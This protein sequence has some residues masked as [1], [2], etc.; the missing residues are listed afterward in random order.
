MVSLLKQILV[1]VG[2]VMASAR[3]GPWENNQGYNCAKCSEAAKYKMTDKTRLCETCAETRCQNTNSKGYRCT[4]DQISEDDLCS[5]HSGKV[6]KERNRCTNTSSKQK[7]CEKQQAFGTLCGDH[8]EKQCRGKCLVRVNGELCGKEKDGPNFCVA[9]KCPQC[10]HLAC[11]REVPEKGL[12]EECKKCKRPGCKQP[13]AGQ[14]VGYC[15]SECGRMMCSRKGCLT[16]NRGGDHS[17]CGVHTCALKVDGVFPCR[18][19]VLD[20]VENIH[21]FCRRHHDLKFKP[22]LDLTGRRNYPRAGALMLNKKHDQETHFRFEEWVFTMD[23]H[24]LL[25]KDKVQYDP[26]ESQLACSIYQDI[27]GDTCADYC[28]GGSVSGTLCARHLKCDIQESKNNATLLEGVAYQTWKKIFDALTNFAFMQDGKGTAAKYR[29]VVK[30]QFEQLALGD[31]LDPK[32]KLKEEKGFLTSDGGAGSHFKDLKVVKGEIMRSRNGFGSQE[33]PVGKNRITFYC[34]KITGQPGKTFEKAKNKEKILKALQE[35]VVAQLASVATA[36]DRRNS[37][38]IL[39]RFAAPSDGLV[40]SAGNLRGGG[41]GGLAGEAR[42][43]ASQ[44]PQTRVGSAA[45]PAAPALAP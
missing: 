15:S 25:S 7:R 14:D 16:V 9:H 6:N 13:V 28:K 21:S 36:Q 45:P 12:C 41:G 17:C 43:R 24:T 10:G 39:S 33:A 2:V 22:V 29:D 42:A 20:S 38:D 19:E 1:C 26:K 8:Y 23:G 34:L 5:H 31:F 3:K 40:R 30:G 37:Y 4:R 35:T 44:T 32:I 27:H 18:E 11:Q